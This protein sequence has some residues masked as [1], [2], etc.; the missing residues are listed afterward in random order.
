MGSDDEREPKLQGDNWVKEENRTE[1][2]K[3][4]KIQVKE[5]NRTEVKKRQKIQ[6]HEKGE[7]F[8]VESWPLVNRTIRELPEITKL[9]MQV[10]WH[11]DKNT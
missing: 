9:R 1:V 11:I 2:K 6:A 7:T 3:R 4:Q 8:A 10:S 5:E